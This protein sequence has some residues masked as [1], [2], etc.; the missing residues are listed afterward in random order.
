MTKKEYSHLS[1]E[2]LWSQKAFQYRVDKIAEWIQAQARGRNGTG[3]GELDF[4]SR[5]LNV[6]QMSFEYWL[7]ERDWH[8]AYWQERRARSGSRS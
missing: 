6:W 2:P 7:V 5:F 8:L 4:E 1:D 3:P